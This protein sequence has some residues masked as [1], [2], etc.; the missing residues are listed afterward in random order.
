M[1]FSIIL[2]ALGCFGL[3]WGY[4]HAAGWRAG[5]K[6]AYAGIDGLLNAIQQIKDQR[7]KEQV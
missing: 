2:L 5:L 3:G 7:A 4:G 1:Y 6:K